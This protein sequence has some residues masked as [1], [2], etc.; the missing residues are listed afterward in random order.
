[1]RL[2]QLDLNLFLVFDAVY[3]QRNLTRAAE[4][5]NITQPAVSNAL[6]RL[7]DKLNDPLFVR[8]TEG[9]TPTPLSENIIGRVQEGLQLLYISATEGDVFDPAATDKVFR[10][11]MNDMTESM[12]LPG[13]VERLQREAP[14]VGLECHY[15]PRT[16]IE[17]ELTAGTL[18]FAIDVP[19]MTSNQ[20][21]HESLLT[22]RNVCVVR[23]DHPLIGDS[24]SLTE[25]LALKH[26]RV[27]ARRKGE[28]FEDIALNRLGRKRHVQLR[29]QHHQVSPQLVERTDMAL[30]IP[31]TMA[32]KYNLKVLELPYELAP[33]DMHLFWHK[34][35]DRDKANLWMRGLLQEISSASQK[36]ALGA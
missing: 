36:N 5:L 12:M 23:R 2:N 18:D 28:S 20:V 30:T 11:S 24:I 13:L 27:S 4:V 14:G 34:S 33:V 1:M 25:Y 32:H 15:V 35:A 8:T 3:Q 29:V 9:M 7:R 17:R 31:I 22:Q 16:D 21:C 26:I 10:I 6:T 19:Q